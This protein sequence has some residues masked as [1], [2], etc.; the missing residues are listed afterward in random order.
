MN[1]RLQVMVDYDYDIIIIGSGPGGVAAGIYCRRALLKT[2]IIEKG[3]IGGMLLVTDRIENYPG[4]SSIHGYELAQE[5]EDH[6]KGYEPEILQTA[7][8]SLTVADDVARTKTVLTEKGEFTAPA[9][10]ISTG[11]TPRS[12]DVEGYK[13]FFG[14]GVST[15]AI[16]DAVFFKGKIVAVIGGGDAAVDESIYLSRFVEKLYLIHRRDE[17]RAEVILQRKLMEKENVEFVWDTVPEKII[18][19]ESVKGLRVKNVKT[20]EVKEIAVDGVFNYTGHSPNT[21]YINADLKTNEGGYIITNQ[22]MESNIPGLY[23]AGDVRAGTFRQAVIAAGE[24][25]M[26]ALSANNYIRNI[27]GIESCT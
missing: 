2:L 1:E 10:I 16:C 26:A 3:P 11:G 6:L 15:C 4:F 27:C 22:N 21:D 8:I 19:D 9:A 17:L 14:R 25:A 18:G 5:F 12:L 13:D 20:G 7:V 23:A 24:G